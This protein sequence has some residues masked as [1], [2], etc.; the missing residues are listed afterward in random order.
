VSRAQVSNNTCI[1]CNDE[2]QIIT[3]ANETLILHSEASDGRKAFG[4]TMVVFGLVQPNTIHLTPYL[5]RE[6]AKA[7][8]RQADKEEGK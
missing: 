6:L 7:L 4:S 3:A 1:W 2:F 5:K 8:I